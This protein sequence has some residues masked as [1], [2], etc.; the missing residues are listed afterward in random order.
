MG[1]KGWGGNF[2]WGFVWGCI[3]VNAQG[4][5]WDCKYIPVNAQGEQRGCIVSGDG[6]GV[7]R[8]WV[9]V[10]VCVWGGW[11]KTWVRVYSP[12]FHIVCNF[13]TLS[14]ESYVPFSISY[15][16]Y[17]IFYVLNPICYIRYCILYL[18]YSIL[19]MYIRYIYYVLD[20]KF[21]VLYMVHILTGI[22]LVPS[23]MYYIQDLTSC[24][25]SPMV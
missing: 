2:D 15:F 13:H 18:L 1:G 17:S 19:Y 22:L 14:S 20:S 16:L 10:C 4:P 5:Q 12:I 7:Q 25:L 8:D 11:R 24:I 21:Y 23:L 9:G 6:P 3:P